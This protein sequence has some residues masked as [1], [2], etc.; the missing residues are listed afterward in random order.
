MHPSREIALAALRMATSSDR[1]EEKELKEKYL[2]QEIRVAAVDFGG[3]FISGINKIIERALVASRRE[4]VI[5]NTHL[6]EGAVAGATRDAI[7]QIITKA[8]GGSVGGKIGIARSQGHVSVAV[9]FG[10][11][12]LNLNEVAV[13]LSHRAI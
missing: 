13:G 7:S 3:D 10:V 1:A 2:S 12:L 11:S 9:F 5:G 4:G 8:L 6:E